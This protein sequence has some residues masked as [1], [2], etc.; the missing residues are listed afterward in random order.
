MSSLSAHEV[1]A[2]HG[3]WCR[4]EQQQGSCWVLQKEAPGALYYVLSPACL[5]SAGVGVNKDLLK[6]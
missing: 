4:A 5:I 1:P 6:E 2:L 3:L